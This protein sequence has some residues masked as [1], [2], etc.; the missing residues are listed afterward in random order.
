MS[1]VDFNKI[2][3]AVEQGIVAS[4]QTDSKQWA[5]WKEWRKS[6]DK[7]DEEMHDTLLRV[8]LELGHLKTE[9]KDY[10]DA[11]MAQNGRINKLEKQGQY[12]SG[13]VVISTLF[14]IPLI[15]Y[16]FTTGLNHS[17][18]SIEEV[19]GN[20]AKLEELHSTK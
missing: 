8:E 14:V 7:K 3:E 18:K 19:K 17:A 20:I 13:A 1:D 10:K 15:T 9:M 6:R 2:M 16:I 4:K 11:K 5:E 12:V